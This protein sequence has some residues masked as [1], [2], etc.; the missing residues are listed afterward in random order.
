[1]R[2]SETRRYSREPL[3]ETEAAFLASGVGRE[4]AFQEFRG[5]LKQ[6]PEAY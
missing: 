6:N 5:A 1:M 4:E 3:R 2:R